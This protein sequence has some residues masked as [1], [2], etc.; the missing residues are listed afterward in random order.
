M[1]SKKI[2]RVEVPVVTK[3]LLKQQ[4]YKC[5]LCDGSLKAG[6]KKDPVLDHDHTTGNVRSVL[7]RN[8]NGI[9]GK[10]FNLSRRAK[11]KKTESEWIQSLLDYWKQHEVSNHGLIHY[12]HKTD[13]EKR[14]ER[15]KKAK[16]RRARAKKA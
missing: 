11:N 14:L 8:C 7:C 4:Q 1:Q 12:T 3:A 13:E 15:N 10:V 2:K 6:S 9:E 5:A 16:L